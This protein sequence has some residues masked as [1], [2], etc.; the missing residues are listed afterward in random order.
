MASNSFRSRLRN[1]QARRTR[2]N[3]PSSVQPFSVPP[4]PRPRCAGPGCR[5]ARSGMIRR[6]SSP[7]RT[8]S[9]RAAHSISSSRVSG[10]SR[11]LGRP[12]RWCPERPTRC[13][14]VAIERV[15]PSWQTRS[16]EPMS[17]P[18]SSDAVAT[19]AES[20]PA[21][22]RRSLSSRCSLDE[23][24]V[25]G[26][27]PAP[28]PSRSA[29]W[30]VTRS[31]I[32]RV[33]A[34]TSV[35]RCSRIRLGQPVVD[36]RPHLHG[37]HRLQ[38]RGGGHL[39]PQVEPPAVPGVD[40]HAPR[41]AVRLRRWRCRP[42][43][44]PPPRSASGWRRGR[45]AVEVPPTLPDRASSRSSDSARCEPRLS[46]ATAW[47]SSTIDRADV[48]Q[49]P[50]PALAGEQDEQRLRGRHQDVRR[51]LRPSPP[52]RAAGVSPVR[53]SVRISDIR[54]PLRRQLRRG[55]RRAAPPGSSARRSTAP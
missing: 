39:D 28:R 27:R 15:E 53:T 47:I 35:V 18:S 20:S 52:A 38:R 5:A 30:R 37:H 29:R 23:A 44:G 8:A 42:G 55:C 3:S 54:Q 43:T 6:S 22:R 17:I 13:S 51:P 2:A 45:S 1:G 10:K 33:L 4:P 12:P 11:P 34:K 14:R 24:A 25:V 21:L 48:L 49:H 19:R 26:R 9:T 41:G 31:A 50:P 46:S 16:T 32:R 36:L 7:R 40:D